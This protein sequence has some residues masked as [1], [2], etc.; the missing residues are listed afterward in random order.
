MRIS[1]V[2]VAVAMALAMGACG[3]SDEDG[4]PAAS[5]SSDAQ[6]LQARVEKLES[7]A[8]KREA[9]AARKLKAAKRKA[10]AARR[11]ARRAKRDAKRRA[12]EEAAEAEATDVALEQGGGDIIVPDVTGLDHQAAQDVMQGEGLWLLDE[13]D[14]TGQD[15][16]LLWDRNWEV[17]S[18]DPPAGS[19]VSED[20]SITICSKKQG[21]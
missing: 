4:P 13:E 2:L 10:H 17:V 11:E 19:R 18:T 8:E 1:L 21:E 14:C 7:E 3:G 16:M 15:R 12:R 6:A 20:T 5:T 9:E